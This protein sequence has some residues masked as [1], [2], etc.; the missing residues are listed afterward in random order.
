MVSTTG[1]VN[2]T[3]IVDINDAQLVSDLYNGKYNDDDNYTD[4]FDVVAMVKYLAADINKDGA[5]TITD[6]SAVIE[7]DGFEY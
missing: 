3:D 5:V 1:E 6:V 2:Q 4:D 7:S